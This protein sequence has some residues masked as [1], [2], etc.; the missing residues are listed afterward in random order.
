MFP[1][2]IFFTMYNLMFHWLSTVTFNRSFFFFGEDRAPDFFLEDLHPIWRC[3]QSTGL[4]LSTHL[5][6]QILQPSNYRGLTIGI[7]QPSN[8]RG[9]PYMC[10][11]RDKNAAYFVLR[12]IK[13]PRRQANNCLY[14]ILPPSQNNPTPSY[15]FRHT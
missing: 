8:Y 12:P 10:R 7:F 3:L 5:L 11:I 6:Q 14:G 1:W 4:I 2:L 13:S 15:K 9:L